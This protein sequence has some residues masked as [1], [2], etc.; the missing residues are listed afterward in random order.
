MATP[1]SH[2]AAS[3][4]RSSASATPPSHHDSQVAP[5]S[6]RPHLSRS[7][8]YTWAT[9][10]GAAA[11]SRYSAR[12]TTKPATRCTSRLRTE[13]S[14]QA[15]SASCPTAFPGSNAHR[16]GGGAFQMMQFH[17]STSGSRQV[18]THSTRVA[19]KLT[20]LRARPDARRPA[21]HGSEHTKSKPHTPTNPRTHGNTYTE[22]RSDL[23]LS[24]VGRRPRSPC[25][26]AAR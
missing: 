8:R 6:T 2:Q 4:A 20:S 17:F 22:L 23:S 14:S 18:S 7:A 16:G 9:S 13:S 1:S 5:L 21:K 26:L 19:S 10:A 15:T 11:A 12:S 24:R 25:Y 3:D